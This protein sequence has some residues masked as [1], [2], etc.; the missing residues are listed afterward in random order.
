MPRPREMQA[1]CRSTRDSKEI[2]A[3]LLPGRVRRMGPR[4]ST[5][6]SKEIE[7]VEQEQR[8]VDDGASQH[9]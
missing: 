3:G 8:D 6:D 9:P 1:V 4:R 7:A 2:E 5:R